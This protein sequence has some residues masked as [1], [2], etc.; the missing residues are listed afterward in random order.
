MKLAELRNLTK[1]EL[2][3]KLFS[4]K[5]ELSKLNYMKRSGQVDKPH[6]FKQLRKTIARIQ[7]L[8]REPQSIKKE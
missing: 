7:T 3:L 6:Q 5:E 2:S 4:F 1:E 8:L